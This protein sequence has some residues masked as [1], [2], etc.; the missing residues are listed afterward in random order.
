MLKL[1]LHSSSLFCTENWLFDFSD[2]PFGP[3]NMLENRDA[4]GLA[5]AAGAY[6]E[7]RAAL[8]RTG[9]RIC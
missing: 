1:F 8:L 6:A 2:S 4:I 3:P 5:D 7:A 9:W